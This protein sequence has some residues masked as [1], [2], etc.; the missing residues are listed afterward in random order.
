M[1][2]ESEEANASNEPYMIDEE[3]EHLGG[4][5]FETVRDLVVYAPD[6]VLHAL[7]AS[8]PE[9]FAWFV[10]GSKRESRPSKHTMEREA[11]TIIN[12]LFDHCL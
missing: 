11:Q 7:M 6:D 4:K 8:C 9:S 5:L 10:D 1:P 3:E 2:P 12:Y